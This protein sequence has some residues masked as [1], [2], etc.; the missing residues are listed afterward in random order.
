MTPRP[1]T[2]TPE[3]P[4]LSIKAGDVLM[5][6]PRCHASGYIV[7]PPGDDV[8]CYRCN[9]SGWVAAPPLKGPRHWPW[10]QRIVDKLWRKR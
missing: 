3:S 10:L 8:P 1:Q 2:E 4:S 9:G 7:V 6:C 5:M